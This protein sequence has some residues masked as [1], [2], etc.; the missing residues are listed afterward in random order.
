[1]GKTIKS[2]DVNGGFLELI[3]ISDNHYTVIKVFTGNAQNGACK[4]ENVPFKNEEDATKFFD[5]QK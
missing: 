2:K 3:Q 5:N 4:T 1:M